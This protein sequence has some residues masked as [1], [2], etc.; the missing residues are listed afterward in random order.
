M[1]FVDYGKFSSLGLKLHDTCQLTS[2]IKIFTLEVVLVRLN[3]G[4]NIN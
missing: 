3:L 1:N 4:E 2:W